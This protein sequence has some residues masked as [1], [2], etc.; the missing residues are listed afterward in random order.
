MFIQ[1][2]LSQ[3]SLS[4]Y[5]NLH[6]ILSCLELFRVKLTTKQ[7]FFLVY[8]CIFLLRTYLKPPAYENIFL[9]VY[10]WVYIEYQPML[11]NDDRGGGGKKGGKGVK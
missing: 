1:R 9:L 5:L 7:D 2:F 8:W 4:Y 11:G 3:Y 6:P 10:H